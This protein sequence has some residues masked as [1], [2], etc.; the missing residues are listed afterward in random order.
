MKALLID[1]QGAGSVGRAVV[2]WIPAG[3]RSVAGVFEEKKIEYDFAVV[4]D[5]LHSKK[6]FV[7]YESYFVSAM[8]SDRP[9]VKAASN[10]I[11]SGKKN[12]ILG[13]PITFDVKSSL[14]ELQADVAVIGEG[15][16]SISRL[17]EAGLK[18]DA[19]PD[20]D[21]LS[22][23][24]GIAYRKNGALKTNPGDPLFSKEE[25]NSFRPSTSI[26]TKYPLFEYAGVAVEILRGCS[27]FHR[28]KNYHGRKCPPNCNNCKS[29]DLEARLKCPI[30]V[31][32]GCGFCS[33]GGL[34]GPPRSRDQEFIVD[35]MKSLVQIGVKKISFIVPDPLDYKRE[36]LVAPAPLTDPAKPEPNYEELDK[37][38]SGIWDIAEIASG[39]VMVTI[40]DVKATLVTDRSAELLKKYFSTSIIGLGC[41]SGSEEHCLNLGRGYSPK[42][43]ERAVRILTNKGIFPKINLI[44]GL[45]GQDEKT[46]NETLK[47]MKR[48]ENKVLY[49][50]AARFESL[51]ATAFESCPSDCGP[52]SDDNIKLVFEK[53]NDIHERHI[54]G[55]L[56]ERW[57]V[58]IGV[59]KGNIV[60]D[61][62]K[63]YPRGPQRKFRKLAR[64][65]GYPL[66]RSRDLSLMA[67]V[68]RITNPSKDLKTGDLR[69]V[70]IVGH[71]L[72]GFRVIPDG[73]ILKEAS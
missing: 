70:E 64:V 25:L 54:K 20:F 9:A 17:L 51:P 53:V 38:C 4:E 68:V 46:V 33:V 30:G 28:A 31:P 2:E 69:D 16:K 57:K 63:H 26:V 29:E 24:R 1:A 13:G 59:Y 56:G 6:K 11:K 67:T 18:D 19:L 40:R 73:K 43:V 32:A 61:G 10:F 42:E 60:G 72:M 44:V 27:N 62:G 34:Y 5:F 7:D 23:I 35:E 8:S 65:V 36:E 71:S 47:F 14:I 21:D 45:P 48:L 39:N 58:L 12:L 37:L 55:L 49:F 50:D 3:M 15:E 52:I 41:E 22:R 66:S